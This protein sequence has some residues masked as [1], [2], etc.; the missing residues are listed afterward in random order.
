MFVCRLHE[1]TKMELDQVSKSSNKST[2]SVDAVHKKQSRSSG[3]T[4]SVFSRGASGG[5]RPGLRWLT[6][7]NG[8]QAGGDGQGFG[9]KCHKCSKTGHFQKYC[10][11]PGAFHKLKVHSVVEYEERD[12][13]LQH[14]VESVT[15]CRGCWSK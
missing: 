14:F 1:S 8:R 10:K 3:S 4:G 2:V 9:H 13:D 11:T 6:P 12:E 5:R 7:G 15:I